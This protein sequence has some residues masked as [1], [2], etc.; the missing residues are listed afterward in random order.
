MKSASNGIQKYGIDR[1]EPA[2]QAGDGFDHELTP[3]VNASDRVCPAEN[4]VDFPALSSCAA[5]FGDC[6]MPKWLRLQ[7]TA[8]SGKEERNSQSL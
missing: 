4:S 7:V 6:H 8:L 5:S 1:Y 2:L 3:T